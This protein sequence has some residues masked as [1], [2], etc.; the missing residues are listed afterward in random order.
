MKQIFAKAAIVA[1]GVMFA[2]ISF[3]QTQNEPAKLSAEETT[4]VIKT[5]N[6]KP[7]AQIGISKRDSMYFRELIANGNQPI[8]RR[9]NEAGELAKKVD[10]EVGDSVRIFITRSA[11]GFVVFYDVFRKVGSKNTN[12]VVKTRVAGEPAL[13]GKAIART[14]RSVTEKDGNKTA[15]YTKTSL[16]QVSDEYIEAVKAG[17][18]KLFDNVSTDAEG[19]KINKLYAEINAGGNFTFNGS[20]LHPQFGGAL[21]WE[22]KSMLL[23]VRGNVSWNS[24]NQTAGENELSEDHQVLKNAS[25]NGRYVRYDAK[26]QLGYKF[27]QSVR[28]KDYVAAYVAAGLGYC[29]TDGDAA[30]ASSALVGF[31]AEIGLEAKKAITDNIAVVA[32]AGVGNINKNYHDSKQDFNVAVNGSIGLRFTF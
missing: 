31:T 12:A 9:V 2:E 3:A 25:V 8:V 20:E 32:N 11:N 29:K 13:N 18:A 6:S 14:R 28:M 23:A 24:H 4:L 10:A 1:L 7:A 26:A 15:T 16:N 17:E 22:T 30:E 5:L 19:K 27:V 21:G